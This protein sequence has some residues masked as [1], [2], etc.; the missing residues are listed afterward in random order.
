[1]FSNTMLQML[2]LYVYFT[3][4]LR[5]ICADSR[6][7]HYLHSYQSDYAYRRSQFDNQ[8]NFPDH[9]RIGHHQ[10]DLNLESQ[11]PEYGQ[12]C[13]SSGKGVNYDMVL[14]CININ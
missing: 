3:V 8:W 10:Y 11:L 14:H 9:N 6:Y 13:L 1:M 4:N 5:M 12:Q 2:T 7:N